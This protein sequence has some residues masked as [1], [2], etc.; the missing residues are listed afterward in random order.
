[1]LN[2]KK[3]KSTM[4]DFPILGIFEVHNYHIINQF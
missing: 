3:A 1:M 2:H 4:M